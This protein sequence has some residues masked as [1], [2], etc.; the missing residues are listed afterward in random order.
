MLRIP[1]RSWWSD[2]QPSPEIR[3]CVGS[4]LDQMD[5]KVDVVLS[6]TVPLKCEPVEVFLHGIDQQKVD[7]STEQ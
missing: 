7:K 4:K 2:E 1:G 6:H 5:W 3:A